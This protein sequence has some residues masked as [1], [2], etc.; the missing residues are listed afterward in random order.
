MEPGVKRRRWN[1]E[2]RGGDGTRGKKEEDG[3]RSKE[4]KKEPGVKMRRR[5]QE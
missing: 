4:E 3:T 5:N 1:Q 2:E